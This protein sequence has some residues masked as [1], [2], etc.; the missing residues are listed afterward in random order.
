MV[1]SLKQ[2]TKNNQTFVWICSWPTRPTGYLSTYKVYFSCFGIIENSLALNDSY[3][4]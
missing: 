1:L 4:K 2:K 3:N